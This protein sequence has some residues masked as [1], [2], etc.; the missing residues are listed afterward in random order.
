MRERDRLRLG[1]LVPFLLDEVE[2]AHLGVEGKRHVGE[3]L[4]FDLFDPFHRQAQDLVFRCS[5]KEDT[6]DL[7][8][9]I[10]DRFI[11][12]NHLLTDD[13]CGAIIGLSLGDHGIV[14]NL[15]QL[16]PDSPLAFSGNYIG[17]YPDCL[18]ADFLEDGGLAA[19]LL[20]NGINNLEVIVDDMVAVSKF[21]PGY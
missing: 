13:I 19:L 20:F 21:A 3:G 16:G 18:I 2:P 7:S 17:G 5:D 4:G 11:C 15:Y 10:L 12:H 1:L 9:V 8:C 14:D 6:N